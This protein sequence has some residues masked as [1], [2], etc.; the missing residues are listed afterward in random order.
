MEPNVKIFSVELTNLFTC[1]LDYISYQ[2]FHTLLCSYISFFFF[3]T[4]T[5]AIQIKIVNYKKI[6]QNI[7]RLDM[8][9]N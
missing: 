7:S 2:I 9:E 5:L 3:E 8:K 4:T 1:A 6:T